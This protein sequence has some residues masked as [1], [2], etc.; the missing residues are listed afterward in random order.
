[1]PGRR[2]TY[3]QEY[4]SATVELGDQD[5]QRCLVSTSAPPVW[6]I[7]RSTQDSKKPDEARVEELRKVRT[8]DVSARRSPPP[9]LVEWTPPPPPPPCSPQPWRENILHG[10]ILRPT[11]ERDVFSWSQRHRDFDLYSKAPPLF[12]SLP[13]TIHLAGTL[14]F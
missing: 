1:M 10:N 13:H 6:S 3:C 12:S 11:L 7:S 4:H 14:G 8:R 2:F 5:L 9:Q